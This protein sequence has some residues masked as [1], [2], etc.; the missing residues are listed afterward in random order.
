MCG[1]TTE[2]ICKVVTGDFNFY[3]VFT[4][5][6]NALPFYF[7]TSALTSDGGGKC[8]KQWILV[9]LVFCAANMVAAFYIAK[10]IGDLRALP[11]FDGGG[12]GARPPETSATAIPTAHAEVVDEGGAYTPPKLSNN[13][14][15]MNDTKSSAPQKLMGFFQRTRGDPEQPSTVSRSPNTARERPND[16]SA[17]SLTRVKD[18][19]CYDPWVA[20]YI[21]AFLGFSSWQFYGVGQSATGVGDNCELI[22]NQIVNCFICGFTFLLVGPSLFFCGLCCV[23][24][25]NNFRRR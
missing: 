10:Q 17:G 3:L 5:I 13:D 12:G 19:L 11:E 16:S 7:A 22:E 14:A 15:D 6:I 18:V 25:R 20:V 8:D 21:L 24:S 1:I 9:D 23:T 2:A 4:V